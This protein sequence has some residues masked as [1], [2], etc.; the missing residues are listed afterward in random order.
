MKDVSLLILLTFLKNFW[1]LTSNIFVLLSAVL[2]APQMDVNTKDGQIEVYFGE[3]QN[4]ININLK[5]WKEGDEAN[6]SNLQLATSYY[7]NNTTKKY[8][9]ILTNCC[10]KYASDFQ[11]SVT[12]IT[13]HKFHHHVGQGGAGTYCLRAEAVLDLS[14]KRNSTDRCVRVNGEFYFIFIDKTVFRAAVKEK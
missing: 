13:G 11:A 9:V 10:L 12:E 4:H 8:L 6:V 2:L 3:R 5:I 14:N 7:L 1:T